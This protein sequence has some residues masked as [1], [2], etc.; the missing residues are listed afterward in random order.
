MTVVYLLVGLP[1]MYLYLTSTGSLMARLFSLLLRS[2]LCRRNNK[3]TSSKKQT[4]TTPQHEL[5]AS[6]SRTNSGDKRSTWQTRSSLEA[7]NIHNNSAY[8]SNAASHYG[9]VNYSTLSAVYTQHSRPN[10]APPILGCML[11]LLGYLLTGAAVIGQAQDWS[12]SDALYYSFVSLFTIGLGGIRLEEPN[13]WICAVYLMFGVTL[14]ST[15]AHI[16][17]QEV[18]CALA[19]YKNFVFRKNQMLLH[20]LESG[21]AGTGSGVN[22]PAENIS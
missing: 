1:I 13:L 6:L 17:H 21:G 9:S 22:K 5:N 12:Y 15:C 18:T 10:V 19:N 2:L 16:I 20:D 8:I 3:D 7:R 14:L 11:L 4:G